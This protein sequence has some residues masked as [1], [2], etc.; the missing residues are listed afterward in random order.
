MNALKTTCLLFALASLLALTAGA[1]QRPGNKG[2]LLS[3]LSWVE[4]EKVLTPQTVV[5]IPLGAESKEH[6]PHLKLNTDYVQA[7]YY[8]KQVLKNEDVVV[9]PTLNYG[10]YPSFTEYPGSVTLTLETARDTVV[11]ICRSLAHYGPHR[12]Y[13]LNMGV[14][15]VVPLQMARDL[16]AR[17]GILMNFT[18]LG[19]TYDNS[20]PAKI[21]TAVSDVHDPDAPKILGTHANEWETSCMI[22]IDPEH[23]DMSKAVKDY[24]PSGIPGLRK[25]TRDPNTPGTYSPSGIF[26]DSTPAT[27]EKG[28]KFVKDELQE[29]LNDIETLKKL[30]TH[31]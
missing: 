8:K 17:D 1:Q 6:G 14:S 13:V 15:T 10:Y 22:Y 7:E 25:F 28:E 5:V 21:P 4:A 29:I 30:G 19:N 23:V 12:F 31:L 3:D 27:R 24:H 16:L 26:G 18:G 11:E 2:I 20:P 9:A